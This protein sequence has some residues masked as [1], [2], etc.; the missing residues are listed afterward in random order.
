M[1]KKSNPIFKKMESSRRHILK[2]LR[3][4]LSQPQT[5]QAR[6]KVLKMIKE[7]MLFAL[8]GLIYETLHNIDEKWE[9]QWLEDRKGLKI[10]S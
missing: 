5:K 8:D 6:L 9:D 10:F 2:H 3:D 7:D 1:K 4:I